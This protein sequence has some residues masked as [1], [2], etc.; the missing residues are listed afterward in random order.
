M[1]RIDLHTHSS[2]SDGSLSPERLVRLAASSNLS[3]IALTDHDVLHGLPEALETGRQAGIEVIAGCELSVNDGSRDVHL[4]G[5]W[6]PPDPFSELGQAL[7]HLNR[8]RHERNLR[9]MERL[10]GAGVAIEYDEVLALAKGS[11]GRPHIAQVLINKGMARNFQEAF[12]RYIGR[13]GKAYVPKEPFDIAKGIRLLRESGA[14]AIVAHPQQM[15]LSGAQLES[16]VGIYRRMGADGLEAYYTDHNE[17]TVKRY[18]RLC[19]QLGMT[20][21]GGSDF[22]GAIKPDIGLG[23]GRGNLCVPESVLTGLKDYRIRMGLPV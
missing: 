22:H 23:I 13:G 5:L 9:I 18:L 16:V 15:G 21:S 20:H 3:A 14:T 8:L 6:V 2:A 1:A 12:I 11:V 4:L 17:R 19:N 10:R 7:H